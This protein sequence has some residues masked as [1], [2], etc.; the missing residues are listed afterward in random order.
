[1]SPSLRFSAVLGSLL[2]ASACSVPTSTS[3]PNSERADE[4]HECPANAELNS[5][6]GTQRRCVDTDSGQ[7]VDTECCADVCAGADWREQANGTVCAWGD[8]PGDPDAQA[9]RFAPRTCCDLNDQL[10]FGVAVTVGDT[11][12]DVAGGR[13]VAVACCESAPDVCHPAVASEL[14]ECVE[15]MMEEAESD[16]E[17][18]AMLYSEALELCANE[19][20]LQG[21]MLDSLCF[22]DPDSEFCQVDFEAFATQYASACEAELESEYSCLFGQV[23]SEVFENPRFLF[24]EKS[25]LVLADA[26]ALTANEQSRILLTVGESGADSDISLQEAFAFVDSGEINKSRFWDG[27]NDLP[28]VAYEFG[29]GD[30]SF[31]AIFQADTGVLAARIL[32]G[33]FYDGTTA[34][35]LGCEM[36]VGPGWAA[37]SEDED[38]GGGLR[39]EGRIDEHPWEGTIGKC[40]DISLGQG[41]PSDCGDCASEADCSFE[42]GL[43]CS[44]LTI[45]DTGF[46]RAAWMFGGFSALSTSSIPANGI[47]EQDVF[48]YGLATVPEDASITFNLTHSDV[49]AL[50]IT[51]IPAGRDGGS[52]ATIFTGATDASPGQTSLSISR[53]D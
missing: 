28:F 20:D 11:C 52:L 30:N 32:D 19:G 36:Q 1:M 40:V 46:C 10:S 13:E 12:Q 7:F 24:V 53:F 26:Q 51:V 17:A 5:A 47:A 48:V 9:G 31:G 39:C 45:F 33:D 29:V 18:S 2:L 49:S 3:G 4:A 50:N 6:E 15:N 42:N 21:P 8:E 41:D 14:R 22:S 25:K 16:S 23:Y 27:S 38:C 44:G 35:D 43:L 34:A 37:C